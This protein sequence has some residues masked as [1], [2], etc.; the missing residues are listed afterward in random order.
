MLSCSRLKFYSTCE[1][2]GE[3]GN[4]VTQNDDEEEEKEIVFEEASKEQS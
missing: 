4:T 3:V 1:P 2:E